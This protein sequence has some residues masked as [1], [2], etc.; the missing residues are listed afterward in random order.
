MKLTVKNFRGIEAA[1]LDLS[2]RVTLIGAENHQGKTSILQALAATLTG[3]P[4]V[5]R[6]VIKSRAGCMVRT[7]APG[8]SAILIKDG[9]SREVS[10]PSCKV[11][12]DG[13]PPHASEYA[14]GLVD[15]M[16]LDEKTRPV[17]M[18]RILGAQAGAADLQQDLE[19]AGIAAQRIELTIAAVFGSN[20]APGRGW[21]AAHDSAKQTGAQLKGAW[22]NTAGMRWG[23]SQS[24]KWLPQGWADDLATASAEGLETDLANARQDLEAAI[25]TAA[26]DAAELERLREAAGQ[27]SIYEDAIPALAEAEKT[28]EAALEIEQEAL[29]SIRIPSVVETRYACEKCGWEFVIRGKPVAVD[30]AAITAD[31][32]HAAQ[33][34]YSKQ[35]LAV[36]QAKAVFNAAR[37]A[38][39]EANS[40]ASAAARAALQVADAEKRGG[41]AGAVDACREAQRTAE[42]RLNAFKRKQEADQIHANIMKNQL[43]IDALA[44]DGTRKRV[45]ARALETFNGCLAQAC[46]VAGW[47][48]AAVTPDL[49]L[50]VAGRP[51]GLLSASEQ[52]RADVMVRLALA[53]LDKSELVLIDAADILDRAG[54]NGLFAVLSMQ[55]RQAV[56]AVTASK[57]RDGMIEVPDLGRAGIGS[58][59]VV[60]AGRARAL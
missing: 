51:Y 57:N 60:E 49:M 4:L 18:L 21:D 10:W 25:A 53:E 29:K 39:M 47:A 55:K 31:K 24:A 15:L 17:E 33:A 42:I 1:E 14:A 58:T 16:R 23:S 28:A 36:N 26:V 59:Y 54:R 11:V 34:E 52:F 30:A 5:V 9:G 3:N 45:L 41:D 6:D 12:T 32:L 35:L 50:E 40:N 43:I 48:P 27:R 2:G 46:E 13:A 20:G 7:G 37:T 38:C 22:E 19:R 44:P 8:G 56:V